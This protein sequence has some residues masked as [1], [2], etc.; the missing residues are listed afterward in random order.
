VSRIKK[1]YQRVKM[2]YKQ[3][4][5]ERIK[6]SERHGKLNNRLARALLA[7]GFLASAFASI[8]V[9]TR[10]LT[11]EIDGTVAAL[12]AIAV[13]ALKTFRFEQLAKWWWDK[14]H[15]LMIIEAELKP[16]GSNEQDI[17]RQVAKFLPEHYR[18]WPGFEFNKPP[19]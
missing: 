2:S 6:G 8:S 16:D 18:K 9:L 12:P 19:M 7:I 5:D 4:L 1:L 17:K 10:T 15:A 3:E 13:A 14:Y 11:P